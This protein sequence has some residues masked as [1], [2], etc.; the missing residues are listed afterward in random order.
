MPMNTPR[1]LPY[2]CYEPFR[3]SPDYKL[4]VGPTVAV[5]VTNTTIETRRPNIFDDAGIT[6]LWVRDADGVV[7]RVKRQDITY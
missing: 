6:H 4:V 7:R 3:E 5:L 1:T 2:E